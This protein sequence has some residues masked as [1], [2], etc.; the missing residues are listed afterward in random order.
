MN[1]MTAPAAPAVPAPKAP[2]T[3]HTP[4]IKKPIFR[5]SMSQS[6]PSSPLVAVLDSFASDS[7]LSQAV[8]STVDVGMD[9][10]HMPELFRSVENLV[11]RAPPNTPAKAIESGSTA[12]EIGGLVEKTKGKGKEILGR[13]IPAGPAWLGGASGW[14]REWWSGERLGKAVEACLPRRDLDVLVI[15]GTSYSASDGGD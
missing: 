1:S 13:Y 3:P 5:S 14:G 12:S 2:Q 9:H 7:M 15:E 6:S 4:L 11:M 8:G 10:M